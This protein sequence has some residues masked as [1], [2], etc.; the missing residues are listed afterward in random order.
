MSCCPANSEPAVPGQGGTKGLTT[1]NSTTLYVAGPATAK[2]GLIAI[3]DIYG[4]DSGRTKEDAESLGKLGYAVVVVDVANG[5]YVTPET[6]ANMGQ[7]IKDHTFE[8]VAAHLQDAIQYLQQEAN[9]ETIAS[10]GYCYGGWIGAGQSTLDTPA[11]KGNVSFHPSW[12]VENMVKGDGVVEKLVE[13][14]K[15]PQLLLSAGNDPDFVREDGSVE[16]ILKVKADIGMLSDVVD[17]PD[18]LHGWVN[19]G[20]LED[21]VTTAAVMRAWHAATKFLQTVCPL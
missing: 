4:L 5:N 13:K 6:A 10:Y 12:R 21:P 9:V 11:I 19:R 17:F 14:I 16:K 20:D 1:F 15:V 2:A 3:P 18:A 8:K 7:W